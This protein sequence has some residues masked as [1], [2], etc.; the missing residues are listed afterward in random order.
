LRMT[1]WPSPEGFGLLERLVVV[2]A[3][4]DVLFRVNEVLNAPAR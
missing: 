4:E 1:G 2:E 3:M